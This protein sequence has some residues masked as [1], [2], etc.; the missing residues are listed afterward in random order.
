M[1]RNK[2]SIFSTQKKK[3]ILIGLVTSHASYYKAPNRIIT[4]I[5]TLFA[6]FN[7]REY[8]EQNGKIKGELIYTI[9]YVLILLLID[10]AI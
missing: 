10:V 9:F 1:F 5:E 3:I 8:I 7:I 4:K 2:E 6:E